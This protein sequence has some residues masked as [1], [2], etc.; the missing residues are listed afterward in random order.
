VRAVPIDLA[1]VAGRVA[2]AAL[3]VADPRTGRRARVAVDGAVA[4]DTAL[5]ADAVAEAVAASGRP[6]VRVSAEDFLRPRSVRLEHGAE[7]VDAGY[8]RWYDWSGLRREVLDPLGP[9]GAGT[10][11]PTLWDADR[12]RAT[13]APRQDARPGTVAVVDGPFLLRWE[14]ADA[15]DVAVHL[16]VSAAAAARRLPPADV[17]RVTG[18][19]ARY[20]AETWPADRADVVLRLDDPAHPALVVA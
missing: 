18:A 13:R 14:T 4:A 3:A 9:D 12:D 8:E 20:E 19:W 11:L 16:R 17:H 15:L 5:V 2:D 1:A 10:W 6:V 7:D